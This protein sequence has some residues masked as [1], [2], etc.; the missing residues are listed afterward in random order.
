MK[1]AVGD[2]LQKASMTGVR[3]KCRSFEQKMNIVVGL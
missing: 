1:V 3:P 2:T